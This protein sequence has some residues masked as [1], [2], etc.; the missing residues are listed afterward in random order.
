[1]YI[2]IRALVFVL[3]LFSSLESTLAGIA[4]VIA[5]CLT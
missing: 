3:K 1:M 5:Q 4:A 2:L